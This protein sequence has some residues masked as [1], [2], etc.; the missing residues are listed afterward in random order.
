IVNL[1]AET[2]V[3][4]SIVGPDDFIDTNVVGTFRLLDE[5]RKH[6]VAHPEDEARFRFLHVSTDEVY[7]A[8]GP[9]GAFDE[10]SPY[11]PSSPYSAS[12]AA[13]DHLVPP[14]HHTYGVPVVTTNCSNNYGPYQFPEKLI[15]LTITQALRER[16][17]P[18]YGAGENVRDWIHVE[19]HCRAV[20]AALRRGRVGETYLIGARCERRNIDVV[21]TICDELDRLRPLSGGESYRNLITFVTDRPGHDFRYAINPARIERELGWRP[22]VG[23]V[24]GI[25]ATIEWYIDHGEWTQAIESGAHRE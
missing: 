11:A 3:D 8:L 15:P 12:K 14:Y 1:A 19:D 9:D 23:F 13:S 6:L 5:T 24:E 25:R 7:G 16:P 18:V 20:L 22:Q 17:L 2:H 21:R 10:A 4:R